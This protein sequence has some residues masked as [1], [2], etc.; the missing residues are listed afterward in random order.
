MIF[1]SHGEMAER[2]K[3][4]DP[5]SSLSGRGFESPS[6]HNLLLLRGI[7]SPSDDLVISSLEDCGHRMVEDGLE[8]N[9]N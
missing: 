5:G 2:S 9:T 6:P 1:Y 7:Y 4:L 3:A 8:V